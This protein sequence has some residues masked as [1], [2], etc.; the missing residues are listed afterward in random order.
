MLVVRQVPT[1]SRM[2]DKVGTHHERKYENPFALSDSLIGISSDS[3]DLSESSER[4]DSSE[5]ISKG[6]LPKRVFAKSQTCIR[7]SL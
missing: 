6:N 2:L 1:Q 4:D 3:S 7:L 5:S